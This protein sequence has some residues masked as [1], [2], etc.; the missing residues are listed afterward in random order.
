MR[1][2]I[3]KRRAVMA[4][5][6]A[7]IAAAGVAAVV[8]P[9]TNAL[10]SPGS[11]AASATY[12]GGNGGGRFQGTTVSSPI[13]GTYRIQTNLW[14][15]AVAGGFT[16]NYDTASTQWTVT[17][18][19]ANSYFP[20]AP[21][22]GTPGI[23]SEP[24]ENGVACTTNSDALDKN[25][26][27]AGHG[28]P[29]VNPNNNARDQ[30]ATAATDIKTESFVAEQPPAND[31]INHLTGANNEF[32][33][34]IHAPASYASI[35]AGCHWGSCAPTT[36]TPPGSP[37]PLQMGGVARMDSVWQIS[38]PVT[39]SNGEAWDASY[40]IWLDSNCRPNP[41]GCATQGS[42]L[43]ANPDTLNNPGQ[44]DGAEVMLWVNNQGYNNANPGDANNPTAYA[45]HAGKIQP[46][47][48]PLLVNV[49]I[50]G[51]RQMVNGLA[52]AV[53]FDVWGGRAR[54][55]DNGVRW[56]VISFVARTKGTNFV[57]D[58]AVPNSQPPNGGFDSGIFLKYAA[59]LDDQGLYC[60]TPADASATDA[61]KS[62]IL[63]VQQTICVQ[64]QWWLTSVQA[65][66]E[67][68]NL[69]ASETLGTGRFAVNPVA[70]GGGVNTGGRQAADGTPLVN[71]NDIFSIFASG[72]TPPSNATWSITA[73]NY[74]PITVDPTTGAWIPQGTKTLMGNLTESPG[75]S[76]N[77]RAD[78][79]GPLYNPNA[80]YI[81]H[82]GAT[83]TIS[84]TCNGQTFTSTANLFIDP[85]GRVFNT[86]G[87]GI[88]GA[89]VTLFRSDTQTGT[90][91]QVPN[92]N[93]TIMSPRNRNNPSTTDK[94]GQYRWDV[95][96]GWYKVRA[97]KAGCTA[98]G[99]GASFV[100]SP[101]KQVSSTLPP[102]TN[103]DLVLFCGETTSLPTTVVVRPPGV[104]PISQGGYCAD[105]YVTNNTQAT[106]E[107]FGQFAI[108]AAEHIN[109]SWNM[110]L[111]QQGGTAINVHANPSNPWNKFLAPGQTT[112]S[113]GF[114]TGP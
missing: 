56:N 3:R 18:N 52:Q 7:L 66:F 76:G 20:G 82:D 35:I 1:I 10:A 46:T 40:D 26:N 86:A 54:S 49:P 83:I 70:V 47:G 64:T 57:G 105:V 65:G 94:Y 29:W 69:P 90:F 109:Q 84:I 38:T 59:S 25:C 68:W 44:N 88:Q 77:Y 73:N 12:N 74:F 32:S 111:T 102:I 8:L 107:W 43:P 106:I 67:I 51:V 75:G 99:T 2:V 91:T 95:T 9:V 21:G 4:G 16:M 11:F 97:S 48:V 23:D 41:S 45:A 71:W 100:E 19:T 6:G 98:P 55:F 14:N 33:H 34:Q 72:C 39:P 5:A 62:A 110:V 24:V 96:G 37:F 89:T 30:F 15:P 114:C 108:P 92:G 79:I 27:W 63:P 85:S 78:N 104:R 80:G 113:T 17:G 93:T 87:Q 36:T 42:V 31:G 13:D 60:S 101:A 22:S 50:P 61:T 28:D 53:T 81:M 103:M 112:S 58:P